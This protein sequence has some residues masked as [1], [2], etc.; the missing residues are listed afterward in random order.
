MATTR[1]EFLR[2]S[3]MGVSVSFLAPELFV[4]SAFADGSLPQRILVVLQLDGGN[5]SV[6]TFIPYADDKYRSLRPTLAIPDASIVKLDDR[7]GLHPNLAKLKPLYDARKFAWINNVGFPTLDRSHFRCRDVWQTADDSYGQVQRGVT[8]WLGRYADTYLAAGHTSLTTVS[9]G[10]N[11]ALGVVADEVLPVAVAS[12]ESF[13]VLT[14]N[15]Y[16]NDRAPYVSSIRTIYGY[17]L[18]GD[19]ESI[20]AQGQDTFGAIDLIKT[21]PPASTTAGYANNSLARGFQLAAQL[22]AGNVGTHAIWIR[23]GGF[24]THNAQAEDH[25]ILLTTVADALT[26]FDA[27]LNA[28]GIADR[29]LVLAWSEF[30]RRVLENASAGTDHGKAGTVFVMGNAVRGGTFYGD[31]PNLSNLDQGD[32]RTQVDFRAV[33]ATVIRD[34]FGND[35]LPVLNAPYENLGF[36]GA[37]SPAYDRAVR[38]RR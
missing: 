11:N 30:G 32:L 33:Y 24:D 1:R 29:V 28:R 19:A 6:N 8:G 4:R 38:R 34:W 35:P 15:R 3:A 20:R 9:I 31:V 10:S 17:S 25:N 13:D 2:R 37:L 26:A 12:A 7:M 22:A 14:D 18:N 21:I 23:I 5:D 16:P 36:I 27:D